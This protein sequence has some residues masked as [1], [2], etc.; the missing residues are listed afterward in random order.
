M[1][2][3]EEP[4]EEANCLSSQPSRSILPDGDTSNE[5]PELFY[6]DNVD[7]LQDSLIAIGQ[8]GTIQSIVNTSLL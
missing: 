4:E 3:Q 8:D 1:T 7:C 2:D 6:V 5:V